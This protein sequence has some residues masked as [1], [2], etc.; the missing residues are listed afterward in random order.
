MQKC[1]HLVCF[2]CWL[3]CNEQDS[4]M[5]VLHACNERSRSNVHQRRNVGQCDGRPG[6]RNNF[7]ESQQHRVAATHANRGKGFDLTRYQQQPDHCLQGDPR[8]ANLGSA[9]NTQPSNF[10][11]LS[12]LGVRGCSSGINTHVQ[13]S[14]RKNSCVSPCTYSKPQERERVSN[15][16]HG[17]NKSK[18]ANCRALS[19]CTTLDK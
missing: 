15:F 13:K 3:A 12:A 18:E 4:D 2:M 11:T 8:Q 9:S 10:S 1:Q 17:P 16:Q 5:W 19:I 6:S 7:E 14:S